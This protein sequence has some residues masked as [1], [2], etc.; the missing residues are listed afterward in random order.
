[1]AD[2]SFDAV[3]IG[4]GKEG[5][6]IS[7]YMAL[8]GM[9]V[10]LFE[11]K[12]ELGGAL[13][14][15]PQ[16][17]PGFIA[18]PH[19]EII[20]F[21]MSPVNYD[22]KLEEKG[23]KFILPEVMMSKVF[24]DEKCIVVY[25]AL[26]WSKDLGMPFPRQDIIDKN[27]KELERISPRDADR[28]ATI[29]NTKLW[30]WLMLTYEI[31]FNP[32]PLPGE[33]DPMD[34]LMYNPEEGFDPR[35]PFMTEYELVCDLY[36]SAEMRSFALQWQYF[37]G[38][39]ADDIAPVQL[40]TLPMP[41]FAGLAGMAVAEGGAHNIAHALQR[42]LSEQG[43]QFFVGADVDQVLVENG[44]ARGIRLA[45]GTEI[46]AKRLV[47]TSTEV[48]QTINRLLRDV[49]IDGEI[50]RKINNLRNDRSQL[51]W[52][53]IALHE[54]PE[55]SAASWNPDCGKARWVFFGDADIDYLYREYRYKMQHIKPGQW[56]DK[57]YPSA[58]ITTQW[59][60]S[61]GPPGKHV[62]KVSEGFPPPASWLTER[63]WA[64]IKKE[65]P[66]R[67]RAEWQKY[68]PNMTRDNVIAAHIPTPLDMQRRNANYVEGCMYTTAQ[69]P[70]Q[71]YKLRPI[72]ELAQYQVP[73]IEAFYMASS[74][75][76][77]GS[78]GSLGYS[79]YNCYKR[80]QQ[81]LGLKKPWEEAG[82]MW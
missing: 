80:I 67:I 52:G 38:I 27:L 14:S 71:W 68:A 49:E 23:L 42:V 66:E 15:D 29:V 51:F 24:P 77:C 43:G 6:V 3:V 18:N 47:I 35:Y 79:G 62:G 81:H 59:D 72:P 39:A 19:A 30:K 57:A 10:G 1:M 5:L 28:M 46:E 32:P 16:P 48:G 17:A 22:F 9:T 55:Y 13:C 53:N 45:D 26:E 34:E 75:N 12:H 8:N 82:R 41:A 56:P 63:E 61:Y 50:R 11:Q 2:A 74:S 64:Q 76:H 40:A 65:I 36:E 25:Q 7:N 60:P 21:W 37:N 33:H 31:L 58:S 54:L 69:I 20:A 70:S 4:G 73:G 78:L 44:R